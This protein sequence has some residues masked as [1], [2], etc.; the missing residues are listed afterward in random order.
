[1][2]LCTIES[3]CLELRP[4]LKT[5]CPINKRGIRRSGVIEFLIIADLVG[6]V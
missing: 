3:I 1:M 5:I 2:D 6:Y 4:W